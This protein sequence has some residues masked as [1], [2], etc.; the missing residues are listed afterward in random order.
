MITYAKNSAIN[1]TI[2]GFLKK[3][4]GSAYQKAEE[5]KERG[6]HLEA[7]TDFQTLQIIDLQ[8]QLGI[9]VPKVEQSVSSIQ[10]QLQATE[11]PREFDHDDLQ[12]ATHGLPRSLRTVTLMRLA[13]PV[14]GRSADNLATALRA[15]KPPFTVK[16]IDLPYSRF[17]GLIVCENGTGDVK[18]GKALKRADIGAKTKPMSADECKQTAAV[19]DPNPSLRTFGPPPSRV[20][21]TLIFVG[22]RPLP[23]Q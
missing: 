18:V 2:I 5:A 13:D 9:R 16:V 14:N 15:L 23:P 17:D 4:A 22:H 3:E 21:G 6:D 11:Q 1:G 20:T 12:R 7:L 8:S 19:P 10:K